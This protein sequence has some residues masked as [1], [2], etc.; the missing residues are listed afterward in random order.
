MSSTS[1]HVIFF[2]VTK[3]SGEWS[4]SDLC[5]FSSKA[6]TSHGI[7]YKWSRGNTRGFRPWGHV[8]TWYL[9]MFF[10]SLDVAGKDFWQIMISL[11]IP[12]DP[13]R[14]TWVP[15]H[16]DGSTRTQNKPHMHYFH[17]TG[18]ESIISGHQTS[19]CVTLDFPIKFCVSPSRQ[20]LYFSVFIWRNKQRMLL[21]LASHTS[22]GSVFW[23][24]SCT[25][26][27]CCF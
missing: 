18:S 21:H 27:G 16:P 22:S 12:S 17:L 1:I 2:L 10:L 5:W 19:S 14:E 24:Q 4:D 8:M 20:L 9:N 15:L 7:K 13:S 25:V 6:V 26:L 11:S 3:Y 23:I